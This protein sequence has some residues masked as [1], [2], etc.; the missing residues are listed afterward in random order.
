MD[1]LDLAVLVFGMT[2]YSVIGWVF[3]HLVFSTHLKSALCQLFFCATFAVSLIMFQLV[4][5]E[6]LEV[7]DDSSRWWAWKCSLSFMIV[8]LVILLPFGLF[9]SFAS[10]LSLTGWKRVVLSVLLLGFYVHVFMEI[11]PLTS[12]DPVQ[13]PEGSEV[14]MSQKLQSDCLSR[15]GIIG[16]SITAILAGFGAV[17]TPRQ[18]LAYTRAKSQM[19]KSGGLKSPTGDSFTEAQRR[20]SFIVEQLVK[21]KRTEAGIRYQMNE[22]RR[23]RSTKK[24]ITVGMDEKHDKGAGHPD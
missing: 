24:L 23:S 14:I 8:D 7:M 11:S 16:V 3:L 21:R 18:Y 6:I 22:D 20:L 19:S 15:I 2:V 1:N 5:S 13:I 4:T 17:A 12:D 10:D 9:Y